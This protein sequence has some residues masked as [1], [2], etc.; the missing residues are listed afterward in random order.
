MAN[1]KKTLCAVRALELWCFLDK[2]CRGRENAKKQSEIAGIMGTS[3]RSIRHMTEILTVTHNH[4]VA[5]SVHP[6]YGIYIPSGSG[7][8]RGYL[9]QL[10]ARIKA[11]FRRRRAFDKATAVEVV[12]Q[13]ELDL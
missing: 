13:L 11:L 9:I 12:G 1:N 6:P 2:H 10:D 5:S 3:R 7:E 4:P 8:V